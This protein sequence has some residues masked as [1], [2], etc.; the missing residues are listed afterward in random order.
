MPISTLYIIQTI[1]G[2]QCNRE[3][4]RHNHAPRICTFHGTND[5]NT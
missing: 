5:F 2:T 1:I 4:A 3:S